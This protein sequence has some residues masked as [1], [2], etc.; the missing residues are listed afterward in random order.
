M[1]SIP[2]EIVESKMLSLKSNPNNRKAHF[3]AEVSQ[4]LIDFA[5][6][7]ANTPD[8][9]LGFNSCDSVCLACV[10][11]PSIVKETKRVYAC[12][13]PFGQVAS[14]HM[15][16]DWYGHFKRE[17]NVE[18]ITDINKGKFIELFQLCVQE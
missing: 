10:L 7:S 16:S 11:D 17:A 1:A 4:F 12:V 3:F 5:K 8:S 6:Q 15:I 18:I 14:G 13:E 9:Y 2:F